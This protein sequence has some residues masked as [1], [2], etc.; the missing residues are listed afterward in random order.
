MLLNVTQ[1]FGLTFSNIVGRVIRN[2]CSNRTKTVIANTILRILEAYL[3]N[4]MVIYLTTK[5]IRNPSVP[6]HTMFFRY[7]FSGLREVIIGYA[8]ILQFKDFP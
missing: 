8:L 2:M 6:L 4:F 1:L 3:I 5:A 7:A